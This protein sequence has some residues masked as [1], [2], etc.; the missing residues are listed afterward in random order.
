MLRLIETCGVTNALFVPAAAGALVLA[1][2]REDGF[3]LAARDAYG[4]SPTSEGVCSSAR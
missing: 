2:G 4:A 3:P 1:G